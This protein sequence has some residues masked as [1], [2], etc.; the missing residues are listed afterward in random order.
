MEIT[1]KE[2]QSLHRESL[3][4]LM[5]NLQLHEINVDPLDILAMNKDYGDVYTNNL[6]YLVNNLFGKIFVAEVSEKI[7]G[8]VAGIVEAPDEVSKVEYKEL[9]F[10]RILELIVSEDY[11]GHNIGKILIKEIENYLKSCKCDY[12]NMQVLKNNTAT[13]NLYE[14][15]GYIDRQVDMIK[16][17]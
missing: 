1:I 2:Y 7:V 17:I 3:V 16:R 4:E 10:G 12:I 13:H 15:L 14:K 6:L 5:V 11:R 8:C 9:K